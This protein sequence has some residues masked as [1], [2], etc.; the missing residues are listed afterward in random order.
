MDVEPLIPM[1]A[2]EKQSVSKAIKG[3]VHGVNKSFKTRVAEAVLTTLNRQ[4][5]YKDEDGNIKQGTVFEVGLL[6]FTKKWC[7]GD[8]ATWPI[9]FDFLGARDAVAKMLSE[10]E[11]KTEGSQSGMQVIG[12]IFSYLDFQYFNHRN[13]IFVYGTTRSG[14]T[15]T[16]VQWLL[17]KLN[18]GSLTGQALIA[19]QTVPFLRN[20]SV[21]YINELIH[22]FPNL[23]SKNNGF[24][25]INKRTGAKLLSQSFED[26]SRALSAQW[27]LIFLNECNTIDNQVVDALRIRCNGLV[28]TDFNPSVN[29]WWGASEINESN[30]LFCT[31]KDNRFLN[32]VQ[33]ENIEH[34]RERGELAEVGSYAHWYYQVYYLGNFSTLG[35]GVFTDLVD[36]TSLTFPDDDNLLEIFAIDFGD[37]TDPNALVR[38]RYDSANKIVHVKC[39][40]YQT[41]VTD[42]ALVALFQKLKINTLVFETAT[43]GNTRALNW[44]S[45]GL[46][47]EVRL[48]PC[49]K[50]QVQ[51]GVFNLCENK[52][53]CYDKNSLNEFSNY[54]VKDG[55]FCGADHCIDATRYGFHLLYANLIR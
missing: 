4:V 55:Q 38:L 3:G 54:I 6:K 13:I 45:M 18:D 11:Q 7:E 33:L 2:E 47:R 23:E 29:E 34:I 39:E 19:G 9:M 15:Y 10:D 48:L 53:I 25:V 50:T 5:D 20:G 12:R 51:Q 14:K 46:G 30:K 1:T 31:F 42:V 27:S 26:K 28:I 17:T 32:N 44:R 35:G 36:G 8:K 16:I 40:L 21:N 24:E 22:N 37:V 41:A 43:G 49:E 52:I